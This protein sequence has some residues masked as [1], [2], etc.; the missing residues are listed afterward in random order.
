[1]KE[2]DDATGFPSDAFDPTLLPDHDHEFIGKADL[3]EFARALSAPEST[4]LVALNDWRPIHQRVRRGR[5]RGRRKISKR[6][7]DETREGYVYTV[8]K[9]PF[10]SVVLAWILA[11]C[12]AYLLTR[13]YIW[14][15]ERMTWRGRRQALR[16]NLQS[17]TDH[18]Q[19]RAAAQ[20]LDDYLGNGKWRS[21]DEYAYYDHTTV[22][23]VKEQ[24]KATRLRAQEVGL[25]STLEATRRL[26]ALVEACVKNNAFGV[27]NPRIYR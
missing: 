25:S 22:L 2:T 20:E 5:T 19:W 16:S 17:K 9:W 24:L 6:T 15:Y 8:L 14:T 13:L 21:I 4:P 27:E 11:L 12:L 3:Q 10:L 7:K 23:R 18:A 1:M 26:R